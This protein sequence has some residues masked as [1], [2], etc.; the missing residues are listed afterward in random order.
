MIKEGKLTKK[1][2]CTR[3]GP[4]NGIIIRRSRSVEHL[5]GHVVQIIIT[6]DVLAPLTDF[7]IDL[8]SN[9]ANEVWILADRQGIAIR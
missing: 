3:A 5:K 9:C 6:P 7:G 4:P 2:V 8:I 1:I